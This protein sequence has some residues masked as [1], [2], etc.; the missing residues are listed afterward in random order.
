MN[1]HNKKETHRNRE[2]PAQRGKG[3]KEM[4]EIVRETK[5]HKLGYKI[6]E[7]WR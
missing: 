1:K 6:N 3:V 7:S 4:S 5:R 2:P